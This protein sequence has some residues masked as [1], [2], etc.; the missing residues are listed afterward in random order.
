MRHRSFAGR[1]ALLVLLVRFPLGCAGNDLP[2]DASPDDMLAFADTRLAEHDYFDAVEVLEHFLRSE[3]G[4]S[5]VPYAKLRLGDARYGLEEYILAE[6]EYQDVV[7]DYAASPYVEEAK[8][9]VTRCRFALIHPYNRDQSETEKA[10]RSLTDFQ[11]DY[12]ASSFVPEV[13]EMLAE[14]SDRLARREYEAGRFYQ[15]QRRNR[16]AKI[17]FE[18][19]LKEHPATRWAPKARLGLGEVYLARKR[20]DDAAAHYRRVMEDYPDSE[21]AALARDALARIA[22][23]ETEGT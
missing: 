18:F 1:A 7:E 19:V 6:G 21:E 2:A 14:C 11:R 9:K 5:R 8:F 10:V 23:K 20:W 22:E 4:N 3:P 15:K 13:E 12:P 17:Q 16:S